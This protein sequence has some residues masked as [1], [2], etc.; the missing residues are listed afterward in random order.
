MLLSWSNPALKINPLPKFASY[1]ENMVA[2]K[3][4]SAGCFMLHVHV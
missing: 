2:M 4:K 3:V 1:M